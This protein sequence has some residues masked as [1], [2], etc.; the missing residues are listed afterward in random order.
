MA[1]P[2]PGS[3]PASAALACRRVRSSAR[4][5]PE[6]CGNTTRACSDPATTANST[7]SRSSSMAAA[8]AS[9]AHRNLISG[10]P[11][12]PD[13]SRMITSAASGG[14]GAASA[15]PTASTV[16]RACTSQAPAARYRF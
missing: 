1:V 3:T 4:T 15:A 2:P 11:I 7:P 12:D 6:N 13:S 16:I 14:T 5:I 10:L 8:A 9:S